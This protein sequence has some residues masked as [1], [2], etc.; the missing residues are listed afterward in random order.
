MRKDP[1]WA[2][3]AEAGSFTAAANS[4]ARQADF[5]SPGPCGERSQLSGCDSRQ[6]ATLPGPQ[7][8]FPPEGEDPGGSVGWGPPAPLPSPSSCPSAPSPFVA[9]D[10]EEAGREQALLVVVC[11]K[12]APLDLLTQQ[13]LAVPEPAAS[14]PQWLG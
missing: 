7:D 3:R 14:E 1:A 10:P 8:P 12:T 11:A 9:A 4:P 2:G 6:T 13:K 5:L